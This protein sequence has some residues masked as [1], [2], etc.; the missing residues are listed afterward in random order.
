MLAAIMWTDNVYVNR[1]GRERIVSTNVLQRSM[2]V[3]VDMI[4]NVIGRI[5]KAVIVQLD[6]VLAWMGT[7]A[8]RK[9]F[10]FSNLI[11]FFS[12]IKDLSTKFFCVPFNSFISRL[13]NRSFSNSACSIIY[14]T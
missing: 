4:V 1:A 10:F 9:L 7:L 14:F 2:E 11:S 13:L 3:I 8:Q 5:Q 6:S 12:S